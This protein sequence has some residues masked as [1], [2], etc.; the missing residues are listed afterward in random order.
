M[1]S[2]WIRQTTTTTGTGDLTLATVSGYNTF[3]GAFST[4]Q[5]FRYNILNDSDGSPI[6][7]G[8]GHMSDSTTL[9]RDWVIAT[10]VSGTY[11]PQENSS[12][13][14]T[15]A[16]GTKRVVCTGDASAFMTNPLRAFSRNNTDANRRLIL[17]S[18]YIERQSTTVAI[19]T[20]N[21]LYAWPVFIGDRGPF[22]AI[23]FRGSAT[24][25]DLDMALYRA[26]VDGLPGNLVFGAT[27]V[28]SAAGMFF[29]TISSTVLTPGWY[30]A[31]VN[32][33]T[34]GLSVYRGAL[35][36]DS[37][38][39]LD[40]VNAYPFTYVTQ[41]AGTLPDPFGTPTAIGG[42]MS[43]YYVPAISFRLG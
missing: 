35:L 4:A 13:Q 26:G 27:A 34:T 42:Q 5:R 18:N 8:I 30:W 6:E 19:P 25:I 37:S 3:H 9:V 14:A 38:G 10:M 17:P 36:Q 23:G 28:A 40:P 29:G 41:T 39:W 12:G 31:A 43:S 11:T 33:S 22:D 21:R 20:A 1:L 32:A 16:S 2:N 24:G 15:L 7:I